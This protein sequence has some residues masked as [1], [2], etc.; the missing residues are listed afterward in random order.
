VPTGLQ[1]AVVEIDQ[2]GAVG[3]S[4]ARD[5]NTPLS[6]FL[7]RLG[8][9]G[10]LGVLLGTACGP[11]VADEFRRA[12]SVGTVAGWRQF[13]AK[14]PDG[15]DSAAARRALDH[16]AYEH[17]TLTDPSSEAFLAYME[18]YPESLHIKAA[19]EALDDLAFGRAAETKRYD[20]YLSTRPRGKHAEE[21]QQFLDKGLFDQAA[22]RGAHALRGFLRDRPDSDYRADAWAALE[23]ALVKE[24]GDGGLIL[25]RVEKAGRQIGV[26]SVVGWDAGRALR[27]S[28]LDLGA[29]AAAGVAPDSDG[30]LNLKARVFARREGPAPRNP[31][32]AVLM[33]RTPDGSSVVLT[34]PVKMKRKKRSQNLKLKFGGRLDAPKSTTGG[35]AY[36]FVIEGR[37]LPRSWADFRPI[38]NIASVPVTLLAA[39]P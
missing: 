22:E 33:L 34:A 5:N 25:W 35:R 1:E 12:Q 29:A 4:Q 21:A 2:Y 31:V 3:S 11:T 13:L 28:S 14:Y 38:S 39:S 9:V 27:L 26:D 24:A 19:I 23:K 10:V 15:S 36:I 16:A 30:R 6:V 18:E 7:A 37:E 8:A 17:L 32:T 20:D